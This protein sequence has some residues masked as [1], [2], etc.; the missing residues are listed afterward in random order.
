MIYKFFSWYSSAPLGWR[1]FVVAALVPIQE[2][3]FLEP[4]R[5]ALNAI[6]KVNPAIAI[7]SLPLLLFVGILT[8]LMVGLFVYEFF[9]RIGYTIKSKIVDLAFVVCVFAWVVRPLH[10]IG[11]AGFVAMKI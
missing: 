7:A 3:L 11:C 10:F 2:Y 9:V 1:R 5:G 8:A 6:A 4:C